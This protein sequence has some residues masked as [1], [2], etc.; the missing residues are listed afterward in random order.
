MAEQAS[1]PTM[2][3]VDR[4]LSTLTSLFIEWTEGTTGD[5]E[6]DGYKVYLIE[7]A[8]GIV[9]LQYDGSKNADVLHY[10]IDDL[11]T[12][13]YYSVY[14]Q[15]VNYNGISLESEEAVFVVC[16]APTHID[17]PYF[18][19]STGT[20]LTMGWTKPDYTGGCPIISYA[21]LMQDP[22]AVDFTEIDSET[23]SDKPYLTEH[24]VSSLTEIGDFYK[25]KIQ[26]INEIADITSL[27]IEL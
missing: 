17:S 26:V 9:S 3:T 20:S 25:F 18:I 23:I 1:A 2:P 15:A 22:N 14:V 11:I 16:L 4:S 19:S 7:M 8:T 24:T 5:I 13:E 6:I 21:L 10:T 27:E 12:A